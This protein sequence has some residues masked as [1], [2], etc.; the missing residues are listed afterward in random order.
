MH[1]IGLIL[2]GEGGTETVVTVTANI[3][4]AGE[5]AI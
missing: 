1:K 3:R 4:E 5:I 2:S